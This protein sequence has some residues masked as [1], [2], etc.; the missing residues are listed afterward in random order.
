LSRIVLISTAVSVLVALICALYLP[1]LHNPLLFDDEAFFYT[2]PFAEYATK[3]IGLGLRLPPYFTLAFTQVAWGTYPVWQDLSMH[4]IFSLL[5]HGATVLALFRLIYDVLW[6]VKSRARV[7]DTESARRDIAFFAFAGAALFA[8][9]PV[10]VYG[11][12]YLVQRSIV[13]AT[14]F[15]LFSMI[16]FLRGLKRGSYADAISA[17]LFCNLAVLSK[18]HS[19]LLSGAVVLIAFLAGAERRFALR[20]AI[21]YLVACVPAAMLVIFLSK[22]YVGTSYEPYFADVAAQVEGVFGLNRD[23]L[24]LWSSASIQ[25]GLF[26]KYLGLW[27]WPD[28]SGMAIDI[29]IDFIKQLAPTRIFVN[30]TI[31][32][33]TGAAGVFLLRRGGLP[34]LVG[35]GL[36]YAWILFLVEFTVLRF[37]E[38]FV[39]YRSYLWAPGIV[40]A[41][42]AVMA[43]IPRRI[44]AAALVLVLP[45]LFYQAHDRL[46]TLSDSV[47]VWEDAVAKLPPSEPVPWGSRVLFNLGRAY[48]IEKR[49][50]KSLG[51]TD[52][53]MAQYPGTYQCYY[54]RA[55]V[56][57]ALRE[58]EAGIA[59]FN[60]ALDVDPTKGI[61]YHHIGMALEE[62][63]RVAE[64]KSYYRIAAG[65]GFRGGDFQLN[66]LKS[67]ESGG[68]G[69][70]PA[71]ARTAE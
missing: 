26:F 4:R 13:M 28:T 60:R 47:L 36:L 17:A 51:I 40:L 2:I 35:F 21:L 14:L 48:L 23:Q 68:S 46:V 55:G 65:L 19:V 67:I 29:R 52:R 63:G 33:T 9:H 20:Y 59:Y 57:F 27:L 53:C 42:V 31:F 64:A 11:A 18:E 44:V 43:A 61:A 56:H 10:A 3:P 39:L 34:G 15:A 62:L 50:D 8:I 66:R 1:F 41:V 32:A 30:V 49:A 69:S 25:A 12:G 7:I 58:F 38:P 5:F 54:A 22:G 45:L 6:M 24:N 71:S 16:L 70:Q 37:Q